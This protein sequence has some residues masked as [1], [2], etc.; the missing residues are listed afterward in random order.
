MPAAEVYRAAGSAGMLGAPGRKTNAKVRSVVRPGKAPRSAFFPGMGAVHPEIP[1]IMRSAGTN[2]PGRSTQSRA[3]Q[4]RRPHGSHRGTTTPLCRMPDDTLCAAGPS[5][6]PAAGLRALRWVRRFIGRG[7]VLRFGPT[8]PD[9]RSGSVVHGRTPHNRRGGADQPPFD[10]RPNP[11][12]HGAVPVVR[13]TS[14]GTTRPHTGVL[15]VRVH[16]CARCQGA[17]G[18]RGPPPPLPTSRPCTEHRLAFAPL[19]YPLGSTR[20]KNTCGGGGRPE[21][22]SPADA[23]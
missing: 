18:V 17:G 4:A 7:R 22:G 14:A 2:Q 11:T 16:P 3:E 21:F 20:P 1:P 10:P 8:Q 12:A 13:R 5:S 19:G 9:P 23:G 15:A 6:N